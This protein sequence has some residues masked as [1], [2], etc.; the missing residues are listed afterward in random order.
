MQSINGSTAFVLNGSVNQVLVFSLTEGIPADTDSDIIPSFVR[1]DGN[2]SLPI[3]FN[4]S[5]TEFLISSV[6][7]YRDE[8][9]YTLLASQGRIQRWFDT[10][11]R[12][13][14]F[15]KYLKYFLPARIPW[16]PPG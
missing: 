5:L 12:N 9:N 4:Y 7:I 6:D 13:P 8:G 11:R 15:S 3:F 1:Y 16:Q 2:S 14:P 10:I